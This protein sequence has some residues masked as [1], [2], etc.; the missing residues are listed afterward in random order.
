MVL[1]VQFDVVWSTRYTPVFLS[2]SALPCLS[3]LKDCYFEYILD[4]VFLVRPLCVHHDT[5]VSVIFF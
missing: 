5:Y 4:A 3:I 2:V 1:A